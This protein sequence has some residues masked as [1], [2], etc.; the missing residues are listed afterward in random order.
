[1]SALGTARIAIEP[2]R[3]RIDEKV[4]VRVLGLQPKGTVVLRARM[5]GDWSSYASFEADP[6]GVVDV[7]SQPALS[8]T[9]EGIDQMGLFWSMAAQDEVKALSFIFESPLTPT[10]ATLTAEVGGEVVA[11]G[12]LERT[13]VAPGV[14]VIPVREQGLVGTLFR[15]DSD[16]PR[17]AIID[18]GG[19]IG[20]LLER[21]AAL[22]AS[23]GYAALALAYFGIEGLPPDLFRIPL[24]YFETAI[25]WLQ[26]QEGV[27]SD[28]V[29]VM[30]ESRGGELARGMP[31]CCGSWSP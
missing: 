15:P 6:T 22:L 20:G 23:H 3:A 17:P 11:S 28:R 24:E 7:S 10:M 29:A 27:A 2:A 18:L 26:V 4:R 19:S 5:N 8:G 9:Y 1:M 12:T 31:G 13:H 21:R 25:R 30:G 16:G 14:R